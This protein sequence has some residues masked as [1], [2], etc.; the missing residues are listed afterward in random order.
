MVKGQILL[1]FF[2]YVMGSI[3]FQNSNEYET[4]TADNAENLTEI[5]QL[6][7]GWVHN[8][9]WS[10]NDNR[11]A[12]LTATGVYIHENEN[13]ATTLHIKELENA[14]WDEGQ[15]IFETNDDEVTYSNDV[16]VSPDST[17]N[18]EDT[19]AGL[20]VVYSSDDGEQI[21]EKQL[22]TGARRLLFS[23]DSER[24]I[25]E[26]LTRDWGTTIFDWNIRTDQISVI[27]YEEYG[28]PVL[29]NVAI[30]SD[31]KW[32]AVA[33]VDNH[34][35]IFDLTTMMLIH[36]LRY[37]GIAHAISF[38]PDSTKL[39]SGSE[40]FVRMT[41]PGWDN[42]I[43]I[44]DM[45]SF[46][47]EAEIN[48][49]RARISGLDFSSDGRYLLSVADWYDT[50]ILW[51]FED[52]EIVAI[53]QTTE[54]PFID[55][56]FIPGQ[57][58]IGLYILGTE[59]I[60]VWTP[61]EIE[62]PSSPHAP[63]G[64]VARFANISN[65]GN[66]FATVGRETHLY[67]NVGL[68]SNERAENPIFFDFSAVETLPQVEYSRSTSVAFNPG[69]TLL[70]VGRVLDQSGFVEVWNLNNLEQQGSITVHEASTVFGNNWVWVAY[71]PSGE[72]LLAGGS[73]H[74]VVI[75]AKNNE[76]ITT[77]TVKNSVEITSVAFSPDGRLIATGT[78]DGTI[79]LWGLPV[80]RR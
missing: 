69:D 43:F 57:Q 41:E 77:I 44:W 2:L 13:F 70:A 29:S 15:R 32:L 27:P 51:E 45:A 17:Q 72:I 37:S 10:P 34:V 19:G 63:T 39:V 5:A 60:Q 35:R 67:D 49:H 7:Q 38:S 16:V 22:G 6:G 66:L 25:V 52:R 4:I 3:A 65:N 58:Q 71:N 54:V 76:V 31:D 1:V 33:D 53:Q 80:T 62:F 23:N 68:S 21:A 61:D 56:F 55:G 24:I 11:L 59:M 46:A 9:E 12:V 8:I 64:L 28:S 78:S 14:R 79:R 74:L 18:A 40:T 36:D 20:I 26:A 73:D 48:G 47:L 75:D 42:S 30:S 50:P